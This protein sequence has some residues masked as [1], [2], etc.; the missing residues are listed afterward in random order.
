M[1]ELKG[2]IGSLKMKGTL[3]DG[4][5]FCCC[6]T[7]CCMYPA[8]GLDAGYTADDLPETIKIWVPVPPLDGF[9]ILT[10][11]GTHYVGATM[12]LDLVDAD[13]VK[14]WGIFL[15]GCGYGDVG[16]P[17]GYGSAGCYVEPFGGSPCLITGDG[18][19]TPGDDL[20]EDQF[21]ATYTIRGFSFAGYCDEYDDPTEDIIVERTSLCEWKT[22]IQVLSHNDH[23]TYIWVAATVSLFFN[24]VAGGITVTTPDCSAYVD[25][26]ESPHPNPTGQYQESARVL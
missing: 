11:D 21:E 8:A 26:T 2:T 25:Q 17:G 13:G 5:L 18:N 9:E 20:V 10:W 15:L 23:V 14:T 12:Q 1:R 24:G 19:Y 7:A 3:A 4:K 16:C 22:T 6:E